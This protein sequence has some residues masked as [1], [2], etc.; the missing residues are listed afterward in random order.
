MIIEIDRDSRANWPKLSVEEV[1]RLL[2]ALGFKPGP[3]GIKEDFLTGSTFIFQE[4]SGAK[5]ARRP[6]TASR[7][8]SLEPDEEPTE[9]QEVWTPD[10]PTHPSRFVAPTLRL[11]Q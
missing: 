5:A 1:G 8:L 7:S 11:L 9:H 4:K 10:E 2:K 6:R 3:V